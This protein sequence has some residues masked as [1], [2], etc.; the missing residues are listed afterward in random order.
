MTNYNNN[1]P[2]SLADLG[3]DILKR[4]EERQ[5]P[6]QNISEYYAEARKLEVEKQAEADA[7]EIV[8]APKQPLTSEQ[9]MGLLT[10]AIEK[11]TAQVIEVKK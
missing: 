1:N 11:L 2:Q 9:Q 8:N 10:E 6:L 5:V 7:L 3:Q 4:I